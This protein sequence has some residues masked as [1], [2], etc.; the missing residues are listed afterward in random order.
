LTLLSTPFVINAQEKGADAILGI[1]HTTDDASQ[2]QI[3]KQGGRY[4]AQYDL[5]ALLTWNIEP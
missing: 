3:F 2:V 1:W 4:F 5:F